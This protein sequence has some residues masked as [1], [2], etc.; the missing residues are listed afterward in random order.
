[1]LQLV[2]VMFTHVI[3]FRTEILVLSVQGLEV[4]NGRGNSWTA[5]CPVQGPEEVLHVIFVCRRWRIPL[6]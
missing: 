4:E 2:E 1:M 3:T 5:E 6:R